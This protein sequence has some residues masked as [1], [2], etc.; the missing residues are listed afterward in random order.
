MAVTAPGLL[1]DAEYVGSWFSVEIDTGDL[2][3]RIEELSTSITN[4]LRTLSVGLILTGMLV[5]SAI[6]VG[7]LQQFSD[8]SWLYI[9]TAI[10]IAFLVVLIYGAVVVTMMIRAARRR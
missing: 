2:T 10:V 5:S 9:Y 7:F 8:Q 4:G 3:Q 6:A 1:A